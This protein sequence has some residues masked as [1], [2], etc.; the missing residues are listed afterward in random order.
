MKGTGNSISMENTARQRSRELGIFVHLKEMQVF[1][2][3]RREVLDDLGE[4][5]VRL[6]LLCTK[7]LGKLD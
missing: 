2:S 4:P 1:L 6:W 3:T 7:V 5:R